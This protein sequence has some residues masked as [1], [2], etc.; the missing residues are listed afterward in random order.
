MFWINVKNHLV[1]NGQ[2]CGIDLNGEERRALSILGVHASPDQVRDSLREKNQKFLTAY[3]HIM[4]TEIP[5]RPS[6][7]DLE[8]CVHRLRE[9]GENGEKLVLPGRLLLNPRGGAIEGTTI[10]GALVCIDDE[11]EDIHLE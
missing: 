2:D 5:L 4:D 6:K 3:I 9:G 7:Y 8:L 1:M 11:A 10:A